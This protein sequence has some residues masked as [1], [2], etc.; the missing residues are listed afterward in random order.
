MFKHDN[1]ENDIIDE[2]SGNP[3]QLEHIEEGPSEVLEFDVF[4][5]C[6]DVWLTNDKECYTKELSD[7]REIENVEYLR[8]KG[9]SDYSVGTYLATN[10]KIITKFA[11]KW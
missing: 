11:D 1:H 6:N 7:M 4:M 10:I 8:I 2:T 5:P 3:S 9:T